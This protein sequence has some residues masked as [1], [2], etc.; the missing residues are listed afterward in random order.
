M[1]DCLIVSN[2][3]DATLEPLIAV[4]R[5]F[6]ANIA[7]C[8]P[9]GGTQQHKDD[10]NSS[11]PSDADCDD[12]SAC[13]KALLHERPAD[14]LVIAG[15]DGTI[16]LAINAM[17]QADRWLPTVI[18]PMGTG[19]DLVRTLQA[20]RDRLLNQEG[21]AETIDFRPIDLIAA[22]LQPNDRRRL[23]ANMMTMGNGAEK[24]RIVTDEEKSRW[25]ALVYVIQFWRTVTD[26]R[27][28][29]TTLREKDRMIASCDVTDI[30]I[31]NG[32]T[33]GGGFKVEPN[34]ELDDGLFS[35]LAIQQ[36]DNL[37]M[38]DLAQ[39]FLMGTHV[40]HE[41]ITACKS[42]SMKIHCQEMMS[43]TIDGEAAQATSTKLET[44]P[45]RL[46]V[47]LC[48]VDSLESLPEWICNSQAIDGMLKSAN[49][50][51]G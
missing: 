44:L 36:G 33:C 30:F 10:E 24:S 29:K 34:A 47:L 40:E 27:Q 20:D 19:N 13:L 31:A 28:F 15:G 14:L 1:L 6:A 50:A 46:S 38:L 4:L 12:N 11:R 37:Q 32:R 3:S 41:L 16:N 22:D 26:I 51:A 23:F 39:R 42:R 5:K 9:S 21:T 7:V 2:K 8:N 45:G 35:V 49:I 43:L 25:G 17:D 48:P 18:Y